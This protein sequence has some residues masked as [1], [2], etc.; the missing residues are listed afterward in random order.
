MGDLFGVLLDEVSKHVHDGGP[1]GDGE[2][3]PR[4]ETFDSRRNR[5]IGSRC[6]APSHI[7]KMHPV[8]IKRGT[9]LKRR[10]RGDPGTP[11]Q[12]TG[13]DCDATDICEESALGH[14]VTLADPVI[15]RPLTNS[16]RSRT[17][18]P[19]RYGRPVTEP[20]VGAEILDAEQQI[21]AVLGDRPLDFISMQAISNIYRAAASI[22]RRAER[23]ILAEHGLSWGGFT[24]LWVLWVWG[25]METAKLAAECDLAKGT[26]TGLLTT[27]EKQ[28]LVE[29]ERL[30]SDRRRVVVHLTEDGRATIETVF[31]IFNAF[32]GEVSAGL[33]EPQKQDL[34]NHLRRVITNATGH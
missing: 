13:R 17:N 28:R 32:E 24:C 26:L 14:G 16:V 25:E 31:P 19:G 8:P 22:R 33:S 3:T 6:V 10:G 1:L 12:M 30:E 2:A 34:A 18:A 21:Q 20:T 27:L 11:D 4:N 5:R 7:C 29:R 23:T 9:A 15:V